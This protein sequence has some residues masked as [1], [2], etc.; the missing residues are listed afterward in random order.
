MNIDLLPFT[1]FE[2]QSCGAASQNR[3]EAQTLTLQLALAP[4]HS[5][6]EPMNGR[7]STNQAFVHC[8]NLLRAAVV[9]ADS[10]PLTITF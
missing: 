3:G 6:Q 7:A 2:L 10:T 4:I 1:A 9:P 5:S 8:G